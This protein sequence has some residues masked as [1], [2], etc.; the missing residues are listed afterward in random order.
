[1]R[2][3]PQQLSKV[4]RQVT[5]SPVASL[6]A[7]QQ[8]TLIDPA[9]SA[10]ADGLTAFADT[11][12]GVI[13]KHQSDK[14]DIQAAT[15]DVG[16]QGYNTAMSGLIKARPD[17]YDHPEDLEK[18]DAELRQQYFGGVT[19]AD[20]L[21]KLNTRADTSLQ[22]DGQ[23]YTFAKNEQAR[24]ELG[25]RTLQTTVDKWEALV[26]G[27]QA[28][29]EEA[30]VGIR[31]VTD[32]LQNSSEFQFSEDRLE[33]AI[34]FLQEAYAGDGSRR[35][36][37]ANTFEND[38]RIS[39]EMKLKLQGY[40]AEAMAMTIVEKEMAQS[41]LYE[42]WDKLAQS[43]SLTRR[44]T[45]TAVTSGLVTAEQEQ[46]WL[47]K[48]RKAAEKRLKDAQSANKLLTT[49]LDR[50]SGTEKGDLVLLWKDSLPRP[51]Y[52]SR[53][54]DSGLP[55]PEFQSQ[56]KRAL[57]RPSGTVV[58]VEEVPKAFRENIRS[59]EE[60]RAN[61]TLEQQVGPED[62]FKFQLYFAAIDGGDTEL[63]AYNMSVNSNPASKMSTVD[64]IAMSTAKTNFR[65]SLKL[66]DW[67][68][69]P[70]ADMAA[71]LALEYVKRGVT[72]EHA[73]EQAEAF[74]DRAYT[75]TQYGPIPTAVYS[76]YMT[77]EQLD[78]RLEAV[79]EELSQGEDSSWVPFSSSDYSVSL[80]TN[81]NFVFYK[82]GTTDFIQVP[83]EVVAG[84][85]S[86]V[87]GEQT[88]KGL[89]QDKI[90]D[91]IFNQ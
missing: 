35:I 88:V 67:Q 91:G 8:Q 5:A 12:T 70:E 58:S 52:L 37:L 81:G 49:P 64:R 78:S 85:S 74:L 33:G 73:L 14:K 80:R 59:V 36:L 3:A 1:M 21:S 22:A 19:D 75:K 10:F 71:A 30:Q 39:P 45:S 90:I 43:N 32:Y 29:P 6:Q 89:T 31:E 23:S 76:K 28:T 69:S 79:V 68:E 4:Q 20:L 42:K 18:A 13:K 84:Q 55:D 53:L 9:S 24:G 50:L 62:S 63:E 41:Q 34:D 83:M 11:A 25:T 51:Q 56:A 57:N 7:P 38:E 60:H 66:E 44:E 77:P 15:A 26:K 54:R 61:G 48:Q 86:E 2:Q 17:I 16:L 65:K 82:K 40:K 46:S 27:G 87:N 47:D 72:Q